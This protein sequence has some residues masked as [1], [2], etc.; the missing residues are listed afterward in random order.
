M[1]LK[2]LE[3]NTGKTK[4]MTGGEGTGTVE[5]SGKWPCGVCKQGVGRN[6]LFSAQN[7]RNGYTE[8][9]VE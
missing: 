3:V 4:V 1:E 2:G 8:N 7:A 9:A 6:S 5:E